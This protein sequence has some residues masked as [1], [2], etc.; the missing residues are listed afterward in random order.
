MSSQPLVRELVPP[1]LVV[2]DDETIRY[3]VAAMA[4]AVWPEIITTWSADEAL[5]V[6]DQ[7]AIKLVVSDVGLVGKSGIELAHALWSRGFRPPVVL[8][9]AHPRSEIVERAGDCVLVRAVLEKPFT[10]K[11]LRETLR[12][13]L[14]DDIDL[15]VP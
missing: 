10:L 13:I 4:R 2:D 6:F 5:Q 14:L 9:S 8:M 3:T 12:E 15:A 1:I 7:T 11:T